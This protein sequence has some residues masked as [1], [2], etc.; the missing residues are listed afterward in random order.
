M[1]LRRSNVRRYAEH[2]PS[3]P[4]PPP[5]SHWSDYLKPGAPWL[6]L[7]FQISIDP[8]MW[9]RE[10]GIP[11]AR[12]N[13]EFCKL[14]EEIKMEAVGRGIGSLASV[15]PELRGPLVSDMGD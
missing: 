10:R 6:E 5:P 7:N 13:E 11:P 15:Q 8:E 12:V 1:R 9:A 14:V 4:P 3:M 2:D